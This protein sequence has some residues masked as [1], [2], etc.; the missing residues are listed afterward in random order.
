M[1]TAISYPL[2]AILV[3]IYN[4]IAITR[5]FLR[6]CERITYP[7]FTV[8]V[9]DDASPDGSASIIEKEF[10]RVELLRTGGDFW[11]TR[12]TNLGVQKAL[13][14][15]VQYVMTINDDVSFEPDFVSRLI[16]TAESAPN[17]LVGSAV[18][19][20]DDHS[21]LWYMGGKISY[22]QGEFFHRMK[23]D[24]GEL[25]WLTGMGVL[26]PRVVFETI[27]KYDEVHLPHYFADSDFSM[28]AREAGFSLAVEPK[29]IVYNRVRESAD[30]VIRRK[31][32]LGTFFS[33]LFT[34]RS[35]AHLPTRTWMFRRH[36]PLPLRPIG[37]AVYYFRFFAKRLLRLLRLR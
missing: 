24:D 29:S 6:D 15:G 10:P 2:V 19:E 25:R 17:M 14:L 7:N 31:A 18:Y 30:D 5:T 4:R 20:Y 9:I 28:R 1:N 33:P 8:I 36:W 34:L 26:I 32:T 35:V 21:R 37:F 11:W 22:L 13:D 12:T 3:P 16:E 27:G 23:E